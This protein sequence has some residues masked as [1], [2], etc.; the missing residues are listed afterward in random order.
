MVSYKLVSYVSPN[1]T[2][3]GLTAGEKGM[4]AGETLWNE[5]RGEEDEVGKPKRQIIHNEVLMAVGSWNPWDNDGDACC[6]TFDSY[7]FKI[8]RLFYHRWFMNPIDGKGKRASIFFHFLCFRV[9]C[10]SPLFTYCLCDPSTSSHE[11]VDSWIYR[12]ECKRW[13]AIS[14]KYNR[15]TRFFTVV[16]RNM[17]LNRNP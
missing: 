9:V 14:K 8:Y 1:A 12:D 5:D 6:G 17:N 3:A 7:A 2:W 11:I 4:R 13:E 15:R 10:N 16:N